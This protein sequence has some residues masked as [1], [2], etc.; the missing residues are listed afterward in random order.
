MVV[1]TV[2]LSDVAV[3]LRLLSVVN[4]LERSVCQEVT[5]TRNIALA[6]GNVKFLW[7]AKRTTATPN[8][9]LRWVKREIWRLSDQ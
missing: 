6:E 8:H 5:L 1:H 3:Q 7:H 9:G 4:S 2:G